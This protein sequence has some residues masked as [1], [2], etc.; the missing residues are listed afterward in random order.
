MKIRYFIISSLI[1]LTAYADLINLT[2]AQKL[3]Q[4]FS[5]QTTSL[6]NNLANGDKVLFRLVWKKNDADLSSSLDFF[7]I[8]LFPFPIYSGIIV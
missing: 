3:H 8:N 6:W 5:N 4:Q 1:G 2:P 7:D